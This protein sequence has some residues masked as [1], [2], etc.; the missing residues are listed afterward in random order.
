MAVKDRD[1]PRGPELLREHRELGAR[2][3]AEA[4]VGNRYRQVCEIISLRSLYFY[5]EES[6]FVERCAQ[7]AHRELSDLGP[8]K[9]I[10]MIAITDMLGLNALHEKIVARIRELEQAESSGASK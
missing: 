8:A 2:E 9:L 1:D 3:S 7:L 6:V 4:A 5:T 10:A